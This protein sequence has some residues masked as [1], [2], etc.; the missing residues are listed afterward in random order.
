VPAISQQECW[1]LTV[2]V[3]QFVTN[4]V[5]DISHEWFVWDPMLSNVSN[6]VS[7][8][9]HSVSHWRVLNLD[10]YCLTSLYGQFSSR[11]PQVV[12]QPAWHAAVCQSLTCARSPHS[13][14]Q[15][16]EPEAV[17]RLTACHQLAR[18]RGLWGTLDFSLVNLEPHIALWQ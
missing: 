9:L 14:H 3:D 7:H 1:Y 10:L 4:C 8:T 17:V 5:Y 16:T 12:Y 2:A 15:P 6:P 11:M 18:A 13:H